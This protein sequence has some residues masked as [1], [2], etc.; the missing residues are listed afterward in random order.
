MVRMFYLVTM[1]QDARNK[2]GKYLYKALSERFFNAQLSGM[3]ILL[4]YGMCVTEVHYTCM[5]YCK[6]AWF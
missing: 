2:P 5:I 4:Y 1:M 3:C 6:K